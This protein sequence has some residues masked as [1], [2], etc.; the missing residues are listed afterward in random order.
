MFD[1]HLHLSDK[2]VL[3]YRQRLL[4]EAIQVGLTGAITCASFVDE[5]SDVLPTS[6]PLYAAYGCHPLEINRLGADGEWRAQLRDVLEAHPKA[7][8]GECG[9]DCGRRNATLPDSESPSLMEQ[10]RALRY[11]FELAIELKRPIVFHCINRWGMFLNELLPVIKELP[12]VLFHSANCSKEI[13]NHPVGARSNVFFSI[14]CAI[15]RPM[16]RNVRDLVDALPLNRMMIETDAPDMFP[17]GGDPLV[18]GQRELL[19][20][21]P[22]NLTRIAQTIAEQ[23]RVV[24]KDLYSVTEENAM[25]FMSSIL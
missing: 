1:A 21:H 22:Y 18:L 23:R 5:W 24:L 7:L 20:N 17:Q 11:H 2:R 9:L 10:A 16:T 4:D 8:V 19:L 14:G 25:R 13:L 15:T 12:A 6:L 3:P